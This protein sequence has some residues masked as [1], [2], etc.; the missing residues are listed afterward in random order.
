M[1]FNDR[2]YALSFVL[3]KIGAGTAEHE[4]VFAKQIA[5]KVVTT[6]LPRIDGAADGP[7]QAAAQRGQGGG[8]PEAASRGRERGRPLRD[9]HLAR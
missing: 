3:A 7:D 5:K 4:R 8:D 9:R 1:N 2:I 6:L